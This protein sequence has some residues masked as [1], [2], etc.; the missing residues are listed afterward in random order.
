MT[1]HALVVGG[2]G[3]LAGV[4][5]WL[6][7]QG[8]HVSIIGRNKGRLER[9]KEQ[10]APHSGSM[11]PLAVDYCEGHA[12]SDAIEQTIQ[13]NGPIECVVSWIHATAPTALS[14]IDLI[15][16]RYAKGEWQLFHVRSSTASISKT[17]AKVSAKCDY[18]QI[19]LGFVL[20]AHGSRW[21]THDEIVS[22]VI[23]AI[24]NG[25]TETVVGT[26]EPWERR[27]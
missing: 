15:V 27:P 13:R 26:L 9:L 3:M 2:T 8:Y 16:S 21:L 12:L 24:E 1:K 17:P 20:C 14:T 11:T 4:S 10:A 22:G 23:S 5:L 7:E 25:Q 6:V 18:H 19:F